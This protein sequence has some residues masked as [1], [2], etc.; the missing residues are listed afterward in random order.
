MAAVTPR[1][2]GLWANDSRRTSYFRMPDMDDGTDLEAAPDAERDGRTALD[3]TIDRIG[4][5]ACGR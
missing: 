1:L 3:R 2:S 5:G 4:M